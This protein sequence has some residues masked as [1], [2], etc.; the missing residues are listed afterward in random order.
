MSKLYLWTLVALVFGI[1]GVAIFK[2]KPML[3][4]DIQAIATIEQGCNLHTGPCSSYLSSGER[5]KLT[6]EPKP[7]P[8]IKPITIKVDIQGIKPLSVEVD[9][10]GV[11]M[12]MGYNHVNLESQSEG[13][14]IGQ[15]VLPVCIHDTMSWEAKVLVQTENGLISAP[16]RFATS[17][18]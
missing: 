4:P 5:I 10:S 9:F 17:K 16:Y 2:V 12:N 18:R 8:V 6:I 11:D 1:S 3:F 15:G 13:V 7:I 14:F